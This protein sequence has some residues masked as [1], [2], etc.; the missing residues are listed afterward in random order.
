MSRKESQN[1]R[2]KPLTDA[3]KRRRVKNLIELGYIERA[4]EIPDGA[5]PA[6]T[7]I[8]A[9]SYYS[10]PM[11]FYAEEEYRCRDCGKKVVWPALEKFRY[12][13]LEKGNMYA[14]RVRC[15]SCHHGS[16]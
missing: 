1:R 9:N 4:S 10:L 11:P 12:Y 13:E 8:P 6:M 2:D 7:K 16:S 5:I 14:R 3:E 15:D